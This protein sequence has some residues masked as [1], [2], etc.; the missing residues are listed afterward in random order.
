MKITSK[1][2]PQTLRNQLKYRFRHQDQFIPYSLG[3]HLI[4]KQGGAVLKTNLGLEEI[5]NIKKMGLGKFEILL[6]NA[7]KNPKTFSLNIQ[8]LNLGE[9]SIQDYF[10]NWMNSLLGVI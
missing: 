5:G 6:S 2:N 4:I 7:E 1:K 10:K 9:K 3:W 8:D